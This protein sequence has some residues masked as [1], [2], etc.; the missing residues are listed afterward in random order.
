MPPEVTYQ[1]LMLNKSADLKPLP[2]CEQTYGLSPVWTRWCCFRATFVLYLFSHWSQWKGFTSEWTVSCRLSSYEH[3]WPFPHW[4]Q[5]YLFFLAFL[6]EELSVSLTGR[7]LFSAPAS[8]E[9]RIP[10]SSFGWFFLMCSWR[11]SHL[12]LE[13]WH[14][15]Q[16]K[17]WDWGNL[18]LAC[19][20]GTK[21][22]RVK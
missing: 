19:P 2:Q 12:L 22:R 5:M 14:C 13:N 21:H 17:P 9:P 1:Y 18:A 3:L 7:T 4:E 6:A 16:E 15:E 20:A 10:L 8:P 11:V